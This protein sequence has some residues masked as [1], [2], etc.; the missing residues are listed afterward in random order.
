MPSEKSI[1]IAPLVTGLVLTS[2]SL[3]RLLDS[4]VS[5]WA[6]TGLVGGVAATLVGAGILLQWR[7]FATGSAETTDR[8][9]AILAGIA[10]VSF[11]VGAALIVV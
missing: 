5:L 11:V 10:L 9:A 7:D 4:G 1:G 6:S 3:D 8:P 2:Q